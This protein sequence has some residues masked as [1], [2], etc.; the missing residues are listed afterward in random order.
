MSSRGEVVVST[1]GTLGDVAPFI[2]L[3]RRLVAS[4]YSVT[5]LSNA[6]WAGLV[7]A[8]GARFVAIAPEDPSQSGRSERSFHRDFIAPSFLASFKAIAD[9]VDGGIR[10]ILVSRTNML[11]VECA[12]RRFG[13]RYIVV[14]LQPSAIASFV[15]PPW[16]LGRL[17]MGPLG[18][19]AQVVL[20]PLVYY[21][22]ELTAPHRRAGQKLRATLGVS[23]LERHS[24]PRIHA[25]HVVLLCPDWFA[26][27]ALDW[28]ANVTASAFPLL[29][30]S[31]RLDAE[32]SDFLN[33]GRRVLVVTP[34]T[35]VTNVEGLAI[36]AGAIA[37]TLDMDLLLLSRH[38][39]VELS[40]SGVLVRPFAPLALV[41][42]LATMIIHHGGIG[43]T[44]E[45]IRA[46]CSQLIL[47][48]KFDQ[49]DNGIR[50]AR[51]G[52]G[53][54]I[55]RD[56]PSR[57]LMIDAA[58]RIASSRHI[59]RQV[60]IASRQSVLSDGLSCIQRLVEEVL[61]GQIR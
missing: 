9:L 4:G 58:T 11:G 42:P 29:D 3:T 23:P 36:K 43:T 56:N 57:Q 22:G 54:A 14:A 6:N 26:L 27:P 19:L 48:G 20:L 5:V 49:P 47:A 45:A 53:G 39:A 31:S 60:K 21:M 34:G 59:A 41:L 15:R 8:E 17:T 24:P 7:Q 55:L 32:L 35:G 44:A 30:V 2:A 37:A 51:L 50:V 10:P 12:A 28:P 25:D 52:L 61:N 40:G 18:R 13:L 16:P 46:G 33:S 1:Q 38:F